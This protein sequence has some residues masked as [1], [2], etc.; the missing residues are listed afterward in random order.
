MHVILILFRCIYWSA[1]SME[2]NLQDGQIVRTS[3][4]G[5][6]STVLFD[7]ATVV[8]PNTLTLDYQTQ[9][10]YWIDA[11]TDV[12]SKSGTDGS[13]YQDILELNKTGLFTRAQSF[14]LEFF[15]GHLYFG[16][17]FSDSVFS[18]NVSSPGS[19]LKQVIEASHDPGSIHVE[20]LE[21]QPP[22]ES[23]W[24]IVKLSVT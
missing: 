11:L 8:R 22:G 10:L 16:E 12:V 13:N 24:C 3:M 7:S 15:K 5:L 18:L 17:W 19:T 14:G 2:G 9:T 1:W 20:D 6:N 23:K 21:R 4:D